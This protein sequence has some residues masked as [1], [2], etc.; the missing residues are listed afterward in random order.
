MT[1]LNLLEQQIKTLLSRVK[2]LEDENSKQDRILST[3]SKKV[4]A[5]E[6]EIGLMRKKHKSDLASIESK[7]KK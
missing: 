5:L 1:D 2:A 7:I 4:N 3:V 6:N